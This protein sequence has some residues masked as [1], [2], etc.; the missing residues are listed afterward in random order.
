M[1]RT[2]AIG[3]VH[4]CLVPLRAVAEAAGVGPDDTLVL[5][6]DYSSRGPNSRGVH[7]WLCDRVEAAPD[8]TVL[9]RGNHEVML[10]D[11]L[12]DPLTFRSWHAVGG[13]ATLASYG[14]AD[15]DLVDADW[16]PGRHRR[17]LENGLRPY[18]ETDT[19][20]FVHASLPPEIGPA[21]ASDAFLY[22]E[23]FN[24]DW[25]PL[26][27]GKTVVCGHAVQRSG[28]PAVTDWGVCI[29]TGCGFGGWL[30]CLDVESGAF[31]QA[32]EGGEARAMHL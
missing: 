24:A 20:V 7:E 10:V 29:D 30:T 15:T 19:H 5:L 12:G 2:L 23:P 26:E 28:V 4:G 1:P 3:D 11:S 8:R 16:L 27:S 18:F 32:S 9:L 22:W 21:E 13:D 31:W 17:L 14:R 25:P 6:G